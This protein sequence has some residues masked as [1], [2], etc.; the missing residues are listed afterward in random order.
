TIELE[1]E[2]VD[3]LTGVAI[4]ADRFHVLAA[5]L[6]VFLPD[7]HFRTQVPGDARTN[8]VGRG[9]LGSGTHVACV[10]GGR[11]VVVLAQDPGGSVQ[12]HLG[13][14]SPVGHAVFALIV[15]LRLRMV[16][17]Q[18]AITATLRL[19]GDCEGKGVP[20]VADR[21]GAL[22]SIGVEAPNTFV[23][24]GGWVQFPFPKHFYLAAVAFLA[25]HSSG[26]GTFHVF[27]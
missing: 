24:P 19:A 23:G 21:T 22:R 11:R 5:L 2:V 1:V 27:A 20:A 7:G 10:T 16:G 3:P 26:S 8:V 15:D 12:V 9:E 13:D 18:V 25:A 17:S 14:Q 4:G 6:P